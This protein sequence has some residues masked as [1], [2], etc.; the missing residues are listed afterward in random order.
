MGVKSLMKNYKTSALLSA[1][2]TASLLNTGCVHSNN[3]PYH[4]NPGVSQQDVYLQ[5]KHANPIYKT[6]LAEMA[7][8]RNQ[9]GVAAA[10]YQELSSTADDPTVSERA[11]EITL[12]TNDITNALTVATRWSQL[13]PDNIQPQAICTI[14][15][16]KEHQPEAS[17][18]Y[19]ERIYT[20]N[21]EQTADYLILIASHLNKEQ[22]QHDLFKAAQ[23]AANALQQNVNAEFML[24][25]SASKLGDFATANQYIDKALK[26]KPDWLQAIVLKT[27]I[28]LDQEKIRP[29]MDYLALQLTQ[30]PDNDAI[31]WMYA[32]LLR[33]TQQIPAAKAQYQ[34]LATSKLFQQDALVT[35]GQLA[36]D[37]KDDIKAL[38]YFA[39]VIAIN[40]DNDA[41]NYYL[42]EINF[43]QHKLDEALSWYSQISHENYY[44]AGH[45]KI[46]T[47]LTE[48]GHSQAALQELDHLAGMFLDDAKLI[49][50]SSAQ[51]MV[52]N[53]QSDVALSA[54][55]QGLSQSPDDIDLL[56][57]R[58]IIAADLEK[59][60]QAEQDLRHVLKLQPD[61]IPGLNALG[62]I[63]INADAHYEEALQYIQKANT[64]DPNNAAILDSLGW[65]EYHLGQTQT[66]LMHL[67]KALSLQV[68]P[69]IA[70]HLGEVL[71][72]D[73]QHQ[74]AIVLWQTSLQQNPKHQILLETMRR[75][76]VDIK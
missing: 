19:L 72:S 16:L 15:L 6:L 3:M 23:I 74:K 31:R 38:D 44:V 52:E 5:A 66:A 27:Q 18:P 59:Y 58:G 4:Q 1:I 34:K 68:D 54:I 55:T 67:Q 49:Y 29:A 71:W 69:E 45:I 61:H 70:A 21:Q 39:Q 33:E 30:Q 8:N 64:L 46:I 43:Y 47:I 60:Q 32:E 17:A 26:T 28:L 57:L 48:Q 62:F 13:A 53:A 63:L 9:I 22:E 51:L 73:G 40:P 35:L 36:Y 7:Y 14:L 65:V 37:E 76:N 42:G 20:L 10:L 12:L 25:F 11:T 24:A 56:Y 2:V 75:F 50:L 41:A